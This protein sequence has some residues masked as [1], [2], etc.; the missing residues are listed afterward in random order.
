[1]KTER[2]HHVSAI[3]GPAQETFDFYT[4]VLGLD[5]I[6]KTVN[7]DDMSTYHLYFG[8]RNLDSRHA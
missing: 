1:M 2:I 7:F 4:K 3:V 5:L 8:D 6:K